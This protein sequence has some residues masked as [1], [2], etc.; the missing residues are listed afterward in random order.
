[1]HVAYQIVL[2]HLGIGPTKEHA[3]LM[4]TMR[5]VDPENRIKQEFAMREQ[6]TNAPILIG[7]R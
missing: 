2:R 7:N 5:H 3:K 6:M 1:M 4:M